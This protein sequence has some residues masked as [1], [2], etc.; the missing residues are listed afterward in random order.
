MQKRKQKL[1]RK[2][3][4]PSHKGWMLSSSIL[5]AYWVRE[6]MDETISPNSFFPT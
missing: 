4:M 5:Q 1:R 2:Y 3:W 6:M